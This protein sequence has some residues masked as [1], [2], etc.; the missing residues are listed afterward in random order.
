MGI[1]TFASCAQQPQRLLIPYKGSVFVQDGVGSKATTRCVYDKEREGH[2]AIDPH[3]SPD[4]NRVAF[5]ADKELVCVDADQ[6]RGAIATLTSGARGLSDVTN[7]L[8]DF[9]AQEE[10]HRSE[11]FWWCPDSRHI[12]FERCSEAHIPTF[13]IMH[14]GDMNEEAQETHKYP[15]AGKRNPEV[16]IGVLDSDDETR[17]VTW[18]DL[19]SPEDDIY[20]CRVQWLPDN[21]LAVQV[22]SRDQC[23][24]ELRRY[25]PL[26]G[27][28][29]YT[30]LLEETTD[31]W[32]NLTN[33]LIAFSRPF[34]H[35]DEVYFVWQ[36]ERSAF[37]HLYL[38]KYASGSCNLVRCITQGDW[39]VEEVACVDVSNDLIFFHGTADSPLEKHL[40]YAPLMAGDPCTEPIRITE[41]GG[42]N[43][44]VMDKRGALVV[45]S[46]APIR[47]FVLSRSRIGTP[48]KV[49]LLCARILNNGDGPASVEIDTVKQIFDAADFA[50]KRIEKVRQRAYS[51]TANF[52]RGSRRHNAP[53]CPLPS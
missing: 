39:I 24:L 49:T 13:T 50:E 27:K 6:E 43:S 1:T 38:Y 23:K 20:V 35:E 40:Y 32:I 18:L 28:S 45:D 5:V 3:L 7:G 44:V 14:Q 33:T 46:R 41:S 10:M 25:T 34:Q 17:S 26:L 22:Q 47:H 53:R 16:S 8:A 9:I 21:S 31:V 29:N 4:G 15:F 12:A 51:A 42:M 11:G 37:S 19:G 30:V 2:G 48:P 52:F 36:S